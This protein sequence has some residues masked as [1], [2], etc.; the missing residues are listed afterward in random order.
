MVNFNA[1]LPALS[2]PHAHSLWLVQGLA[3]PLVGSMVENAVL[4]S[5]FKTMQVFVDARFREHKDVSSSWKWVFLP[6][7]SKYAN[8]S[9][10]RAVQKSTWSIGMSLTRRKASLYYLFWSAY[11]VFF[12]FFFCLQHVLFISLDIRCVNLTVQL[13]YV[14]LAILSCIVSR[15]R[16]HTHYPPSVI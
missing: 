12:F 2:I 15:A 3:S 11:C 1:V 14:S 13:I 7:F 8:L 4:F 9:S 5:T 16:S 6:S 10:R